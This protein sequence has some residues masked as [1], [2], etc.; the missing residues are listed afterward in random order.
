MLFLLSGAAALLFET[1]WF[2][3]RGSLGNSVWASS[4][5]LAELHGRARARQR[6]RRPVGRRALAR[7]LAPTPCSRSVVGAT[8]VGLVLVC[9]CA[10]R[11]LALFCARSWIARCRS[12]RCGWRLAFVLL[13]VPTIAMGATL[14]LLVSALSRRGRDFGRALGRLYGWNTLGGVAGALAGELAC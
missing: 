8:G 9:P 12:T 1:L 14:P 13:L 10:G 4:L 3:R 7:P 11:A 5:V 2:R 6:A